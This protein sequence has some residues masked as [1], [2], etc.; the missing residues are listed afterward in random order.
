MGGVVVGAMVKMTFSLPRNDPVVNVHEPHAR[1]N[2][3]EGNNV[4]CSVQ[5]IVLLQ[6]ILYPFI[7]QTCATLMDLLGI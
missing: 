5:K 7:Y 6:L 3:P 4:S 1:T 2:C